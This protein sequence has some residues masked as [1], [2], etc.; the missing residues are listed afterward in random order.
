MHS[1]GIHA[2]YSQ[3]LLV[4]SSDTN[5]IL[6]HAISHKH[7]TTLKDRESDSW[8]DSVTRSLQENSLQG[9]GPTNSI[10][11]QVPCAIVYLKWKRFRVDKTSRFS[12]LFWKKRENKLARN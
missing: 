1:H 6:F 4:I 7:S 3:R 12:R 11:P 8:N 5:L 2:D 9:N 10:A